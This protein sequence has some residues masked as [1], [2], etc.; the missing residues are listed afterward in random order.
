[1]RIGIAPILVSATLLAAFGTAS[2]Q[3]KKQVANERFA[4][5][6]GDAQP[7]QWKD[8]E[9]IQKNAYACMSDKKTA[10]PVCKAVSDRMIYALFD[11]LSQAHIINA[12]SK[13]GEPTF[14]DEYGRKLI[15]DGKLGPGA[16]YALLIIDERLKYG[17]S[18]YGS[19]LGSTY[20]GKIVHDSLLESQQCKP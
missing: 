14:C 1:M 9:P 18:L 6:I 13:A 8:F 12:L 2:A 20:L 7:V 5:Q 16:S 19:A 4:Q 17:S 11:A 10:S 15:L 3:Q